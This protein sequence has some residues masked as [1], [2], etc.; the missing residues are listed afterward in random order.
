[1]CKKEKIFSKRQLIMKIRDKNNILLHF[2]E[3]LN[4]DN[5]MVQEN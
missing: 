5:S 4:E 1:M 2:R 3:F